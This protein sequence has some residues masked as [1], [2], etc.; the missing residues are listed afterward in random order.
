[1]SET[2]PGI[3][4]DILSIGIAINRGRI[5]IAMPRIIV[6]GPVAETRMTE[7]ARRQ[8]PKSIENI[9]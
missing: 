7:P 2:R 8:E 9:G 6:S 1:M 5:L 4:P 3:V